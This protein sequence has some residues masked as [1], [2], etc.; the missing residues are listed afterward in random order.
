MCGRYTLTIDKSTIEE[1]LGKVLHQR[2]KTELPTST[3]PSA[4]DSIPD[5]RAPLHCSEYPIDAAFPMGYR[6]TTAAL[7]PLLW[8]TQRSH[9]T[10]SCFRSTRPQSYP[11]QTIQLCQCL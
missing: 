8:R 10:H 5:S 3:V 2:R 4:P 1:R 6:K 7:S 11:W 9:R